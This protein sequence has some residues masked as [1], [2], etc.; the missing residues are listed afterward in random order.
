MG[1]TLALVEG[2]GLASQRGCR[3]RVHARLTL[4]YPLKGPVPGEIGGLVSELQAAGKVRWGVLCPH[5][6]PPLPAWRPHLCPSGL[7]PASSSVAGPAP[8]RRSTWACPLVCA[9][10]ALPSPSS[11]PPE[12]CGGMV[13]VR[14]LPPGWGSPGTMDPSQRV[15]V[16][17]TSLSGVPGSSTSSDS[18]CCA[19]TLLS[20]AGC[21]V[22]VRPG[23]WPGS[24]AEVQAS[25]ACRTRQLCR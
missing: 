23:L 7:R 9:E 13:R 24:L 3:V 17:P 10:W 8:W 14:T 2:A 4:G 19:S 15:C 22:R 12:G 21:R 16:G 5:P 1:E 11:G 25:L 18:C 20:S 6:T